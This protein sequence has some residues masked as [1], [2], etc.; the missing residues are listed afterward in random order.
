MKV[1]EEV[2]SGN[3]EVDTSILVKGRTDEIGKVSSSFQMMIDGVLGNIMETVDAVSTISNALAA[4]AQELSTSS[5]EVNASS[6]EISSITQQ[7]A[8]GSQDQVKLI[9]D[10]TKSVTA[11]Q[12][13]FAQKIE[14]I[15]QTAG[16]IENISS[17]VNM[18]ALNASIEAARAG[19]YGRGFAVVADNIRRLAYDSNNS[20]SKVQNTIT[21]LRESLARSIDNIVVSIN[22]SIS[23]GC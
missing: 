7:M 9:A 1:S 6:E 4:S 15:N 18:L 22:Q 2:A 8:K 12:T 23:I 3:L 5:E 14:E 11:L 20:V 16:L 13:E 19:E 17:Q 10:T 21:A